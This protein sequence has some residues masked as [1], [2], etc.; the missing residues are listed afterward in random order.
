MPLENMKVNRLGAQPEAIEDQ[1]SSKSLLTP[2][3]FH[4]SRQALSRPG[5]V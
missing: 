1:T 2:A 4:F 5:I 3:G